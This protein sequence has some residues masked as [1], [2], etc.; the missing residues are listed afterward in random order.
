MVKISRPYLA[1]VT[2][3]AIFGFLPAPAVTWS[4]PPASGDK[5]F[6]YR[7]GVLYFALTDRF[8][9]GDESNNAKVQTDAKG[10][11]HGGDFRGLTAKLPYL[12]EL[13]INVLWISP[14]VDNIDFPVTG[15]G[16]PDW[17]YHGYW[18]ERFDRTDEHF[19]SQ[20]ELR[21]L[22][23]K[24]HGLG[25]K[26]LIDIVV[27]HVG[28]DAG[29][30]KDHPDWFHSRSAEGD[31]ESWLMGLPD[32]RT[33]DKPVADFL[34]DTYLSWIE[35]TGCDG[36]RLDTVKHVDHPF[37]QDF[38]RRIKAKYP[39]FFLLGEVWGGDA[40]GLRPYF[41]AHELDGAFDFSF[42]GSVRAFLEGNG[43][44]VAFDAYLRKR[45]LVP[46]GIVMSH[47]LDSHDEKGFL[48]ESGGDKALFRQAAALQMT[49]TGLPMVYYGDE[50]AR[51]G[52]DW[53][54]NRG[55][56]PWEGAQDKTML[57]LYRELIAARQQHPALRH[58]LH[59]ALLLE[60]DVYG[61]RRT[62]DGDNVVVVV[63]RSTEP[64][65]AV[66]KLP[67]AVAKARKL[68]SLITGTDPLPVREGGEVELALAGRAF[69][70][71]IPMYDQ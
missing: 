22:V 6:D 62:L 8:F 54:A 29:F 57:A 4:A 66:L 67:E 59:E 63:N 56:M 15:A 23:A 32:L 12:Q 49:T 25:I 69:L 52:G 19:G 14:V 58:G 2:I 42:P 9:D 36:F 51:T 11:Y 20:E 71:L 45:H 68:R 21:D 43:R 50:V 33:E 39:H 16:F 24:A 34:I 65:R 31:L 35:K 40:A 55:D 13:G 1:A 37:W 10:A 38:S 44:T 5:A 3:T 60:K 30:Y 28:Y 61:F 17:G 70:V 41:D 48:F 26:V 18:A 46:D 7:D 47:Y 53:P 27:N 64:A